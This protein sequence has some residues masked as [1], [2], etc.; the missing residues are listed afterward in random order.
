MSDKNDE[1]SVSLTRFANGA[2]E[3]R[4]DIEVAKIIDN[5]Q[6]LNTPAEKKRTLI[7]QID[8][9]ANAERNHIVTSSVVQSKLVKTNPIQTS[10]AVGVDRSTGEQVAIELTKNIP[11]QLDFGGNEQAQPAVLKIAR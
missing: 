11:G 5:I 4:I 9:M 10:L 8:F 1:G 7:I 3:E 6:D 2:I